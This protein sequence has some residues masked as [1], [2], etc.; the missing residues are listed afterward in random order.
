MCNGS[1]SDYS[2]LVSY[3]KDPIKYIVNLLVDKTYAFPSLSE[4]EKKKAREKLNS[5]PNPTMY[6]VD[7]YIYRAIMNLKDEKLK[8]SLL[9]AI[10]PGARAFI[11]NAQK[12]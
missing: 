5:L 2:D 4:E 11:K 12:R 10:S 8:N 3:K 7:I 1:Y 9:R 6:G